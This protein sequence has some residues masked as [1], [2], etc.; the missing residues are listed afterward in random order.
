MSFSLDFEFKRRKS[1]CVTFYAS[2]TG[3]FTA[4]SIEKLLDKND[5]ER[6]AKG[7]VSKLVDQKV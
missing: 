3:S 2:G 7:S 5:L 4:L 6:F 1:F